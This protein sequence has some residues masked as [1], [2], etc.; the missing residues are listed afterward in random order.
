MI[1]G[2]PIL[3]LKLP[4]SVILLKMWLKFPCEVANKFAL[5]EGRVK[6]RGA[7]QGACCTLP[8]LKVQLLTL[9]VFA[10]VARLWW[11]WRDI[12]PLL[13]LNAVP[14]A[15]FEFSIMPHDTAPI[16]P[17]SL[18]IFIYQENGRRLL[19][20]DWLLWCLVVVGGQ[21]IV[22]LWRGSSINVIIGVHAHCLHYGLMGITY[23]CLPLKD[24]IELARW[25]LLWCVD[26]D[27][28]IGGKGRLVSQIWFYCSCSC[29]IEVLE[30]LSQLAVNR[31]VSTLRIGMWKCNQGALKSLL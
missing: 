8:S 30:F 5:W 17:S 9:E 31:G 11:W 2:R 28:G 10:Q 24:V 12:L 6:L 23:Y 16:D 20:V 4:L 1:F 29:Q 26:R 3:K 27:H 7:I 14:N 18:L 25:R 19:I 13:I 15:L 22:L 21:I